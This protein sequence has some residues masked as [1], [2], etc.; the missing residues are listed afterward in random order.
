MRLNIRLKWAATN[1]LTILI[2]VFVFACGKD[3]SVP[4][5]GTWKGTYSG[6]TDN[7]SWNVVIS[8][9]G[10]VNGIAVSEVS[11]D[12]LAIVG[13]VNNFGQLSAA[14]GPASSGG[15]FNG[16]MSNNTASGT[17]DTGPDDSGTWTGNKQ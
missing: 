10:A 7:G 13:F 4:F 8:S 11:N 5:K 17:W 1:M 12:T 3:E 2:A 14:F 15:E 9:N 16:L 6:D